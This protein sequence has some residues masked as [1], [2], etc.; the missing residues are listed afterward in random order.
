MLRL[1]ELI[2]SLDDFKITQV[3]VGLHLTA[4]LSRTLGLAYTSGDVA[5]RGVRMAGD[6][7]GRSAKQVAELLLSWNFTEAS[8]GLAAL[9]SLI[10]PE[11]E[12][13][14]GFD[15]LQS[16]KPKRPVIVGH[17]RNLDRSRYPDLTVLEREPKEGDLPDPAC[18][19]ILPQAD[20]VLLSGS[21]FINKTIVRLLQLCQG[22]FVVIAGPSTP[23]SPYLFAQGVSALAGVRP[24]NPEKALNIISQGGGMV[25]LKPFL[26]R[27][28]RFHP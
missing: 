24:R 19:F 10:E 7:I 17:F 12:P 22:A 25:E 20:F 26:D 1:E 4:V 14:N 18:E 15:L 13:G 9:N 28:I 16:L 8:L 5:Q 2:Y 11:G 27:L 21:T 23:M 3:A 6:L